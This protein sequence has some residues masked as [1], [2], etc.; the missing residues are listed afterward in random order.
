[1]WR[2]NRAQQRYWYFLILLFTF[3]AL[4]GFFLH[5]QRIPRKGSVGN[6]E[7]EWWKWKELRALVETEKELRG[8]KSGHNQPDSPNTAASSSSAPLAMNAS[9]FGYL[10]HSDASLEKTQR[11]GP[12]TRVADTTRHHILDHAD[13]L[14]SKDVL[15][16]KETIGRGRMLFANSNAEPHVLQSV[17]NHPESIDA[18]TLSIHPTMK[19]ESIYATHRDASM[20]QRLMARPYTYIH[21]RDIA[22][23]HIYD[24][25]GGSITNLNPTTAI[26][27]SKK[28]L[29]R[30]RMLLSVQKNSKR[31]E[32]ITAMPK[33]SAQSTTDS[34]NSPPMQENF[35]ICQEK[36]SPNSNQGTSNA[37]EIVVATEKLEMCLS[38][39]E[40][41]NYFID[42]RIMSKAKRNVA[43]L[44]NALRAVLPTVSTMHDNNCWNV[45]LNAKLCRSMTRGICVEGSLNGVPFFATVRYFRK[46]V[47]KTLRGN[48]DYNHSTTV[49]L[50]KLFIAGF[51]KCGSS[52][53]YCLITK[54]VSMSNQTYKAGE[55]EKEPH[56]WVS[57]GPSVNHRFPQQSFDLAGYLLNFLPAV[58]SKLNN[59]YSFPIDGSPNL[60]FQWPRFSNTEEIENY[61]LLP[62]VLP[63]ILP[64]SK[65]IVIMRNPADMLYSAFWYSCSTFGIELSEKEL[66]EAPLFF[67]N[68]VIKKI[69]IF[70]KCTRSYPVDKCM[71]DIYP[72]YPGLELMHT[73]L[74][75]LCKRVRLEVGFYYLYVRRWLS[76][77][78]RKQ[79]LFLTSEELKRDIK[80][81][82]HDISNF[83]HLGIEINEKNLKT[84]LD[85]K[86]GPSSNYAHSTSCN[87]VQSIYDYHHNTSL[88]MLNDTR[89]ILNNFYHRFNR[90]LANLLGDDI[91][92]FNFE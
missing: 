64:H 20:N 62:A 89:K 32:S 26:L 56:F 61:C 40:L 34:T 21:E 35:P 68:K 3:I 54:L 24:S 47:I 15:P 17:S 53:L 18:A 70:E 37:L 12:P 72:I 77:V 51:P 85:M 88:Q 29:D 76:V 60:M 55:F 42:H 25:A 91:F 50:P 74:I 48:K 10:G 22:N 13:I 80:K 69:K 6:A 9:Q 58:E 92:L 79:F 38:A 41:T 39:A 81:V 45:G 2:W 8:L 1:M 59:R 5:I 90:K 14:D 67:H 84:L 83:L 7:D 33:R 52:Y 11:V 16:S 31:D 46:S 43:I 36:L 57:E 87:N 65:Y 82:T 78:P 27:L 75:Y 66:A 49:C 44:T 30:G 23:H 4:T 19:A 71:I 73:S 28:S 63:Q 86:H